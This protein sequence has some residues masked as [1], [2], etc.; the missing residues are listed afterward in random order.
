[1]EGLALLVGQKANQ[2]P[3]T[4]KSPWGGA[5]HNCS[6]HTTKTYSWQYF[7]ILSI[8]GSKIETFFVANPSYF[9]EN[10]D[11]RELS[12]LKKLTSLSSVCS[13]KLIYMSIMIDKDMMGGSKD[14]R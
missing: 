9:Q 5:I 2:R 13:P 10:R 11:N 8:Y 12:V 7:S 3:L 4:R 14:K 6:I 1:M